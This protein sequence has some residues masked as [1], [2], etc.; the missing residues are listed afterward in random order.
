MRSLRPGLVMSCHDHDVH[1]DHRAVAWDTSIACFWAS[2]EIW[3]ELGEPIAL[4]R[5]WLYG[6]YAGFDSPPDVR[7]V[8][9]DPAQQR[10][11]AAL[12]CFES[13]DVIRDLVI[14]IESEGPLEFFKTAAQ[15]PHGP[16]AYAAAFGPLPG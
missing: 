9:H 11:L 12:R 1:P 15:A 13:Q 2:S 4:P 3:L 10:K 5:H 7:V 8:G 14:K 6:V 16:D